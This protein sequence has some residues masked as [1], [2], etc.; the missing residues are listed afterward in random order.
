MRATWRPDLAFGC[1]QSVIINIRADKR[2]ERISIETIMTL[3][4]RLQMLESVEPDCLAYVQCVI[5]C[6]TV[7]RCYSIISKHS[8]ILARS[9]SH[10]AIVTDVSKVRMTCKRILKT[11]TFA[12]TQWFKTR[13]AGVK[14]ENGLKISFLKCKKHFRVLL[15]K[16]NLQFCPFLTIQKPRG[17]RKSVSSRRP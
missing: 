10:A 12:I 1:V 17:G 4:V 11:N 7:R 13:S 14:V 8:V 16:K 3:N 5:K 9:S 2:L 15:E 6:S